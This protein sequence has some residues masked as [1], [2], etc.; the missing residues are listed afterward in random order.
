MGELAA[1]LDESEHPRGRTAPTGT[2]HVADISAAP[3]GKL[4]TSSARSSNPIQLLVFGSLLLIALIV[5]ATGLILFNLRDRVIADSER[6]LQNVALVLV[7][8]ADRQIQAIELVQTAMIEQI[9]A[10]GIAS[11]EDFERQLSGRDVHLMLKEKIVGL[12]HVGALTLV[13]SQGKIINYS[14]DWPV[15]TINAAD[16]EFFKAFQSDK[17]LTSFMGEPV[18]NRSSGTWVVQ[19]ARK[20][21]GP[22]G[23]FLGLVVGV[24]ELQYFEHLFGTITLGAESSIALF[25]R[26]GVL[27]ARYPHLESGIGKI[28]AQNAIFQNVLSRADQ[29]VTRLVSV[30]DGKERLAAAHSLARAP[31]V[32]AVFNPVDAVLADWRRAAF[33][34]IGIAALSVFI[35]AGVVFLFIKQL[36]THEL[37]IKA[38]AEKVKSEKLAEQKTILDA[39]LNNMSQGLCMFNSSARLVACN[40]RYIRMYNLSSAAVEPGCPLVDMLQHRRAAGTFV[41]EPQEYAAHLQGEMKQGKTISLITETGDGRTIS[42]VNEPMEN[43]GWVA[44]HEDITEA[45]RQEASFR[46]LFKNN[47]V[48]MWVFDLGS[49]RFLAVN[50]AAIAHYGYSAEQFLAMTVL[51]IRP[52]E[53][54]ER[55]AKFVHQVGGTHNGEQIWRHQKSD[56]AIIDVAIYSR[57]LSYDGHKAALVASIDLTDRKRAE[58]ELRRT[59]I[60]LNGIVEH[61]PLPIIVKDVA[62]LETDAR[63]SRFTLFNRAYEE[64]TGES[65]SQLIGKTAHQIFPK[66]RADLIV[67]SDN[68]TLQSSQA[69]TT[70]EHPIT[71]ANNGTRL[72]TAK[73]TIIRD[74]IGKPQYLLTVVDDVTER[75]LAEQRIAHMAH[76]D[77]LTDLPNRIAFSEYLSS[78][79]DRATKSGDHFAILSIDF[80][81]FKEIND[82]FGH[83]V[84][85][86]FLREIAHRLQAAT[87]GAFLARL[88]GDEFSLIV[89]DGPQPAAA[90]ALADRLLAAIAGDFEIE[91]LRLRIGLSIGVAVYPTDGTDAKLLMNNADAALYRAKDEM[92]GSV[93]FFDR[94][95]DTQLHERRALQN[96]LRLAIDRGEL[97]LHYQPQL[98]MAGG[99]IGLEALVR[100][101]CPKR[102]MVAPGAF[103]PIAEESSLIISIGEWVLREAC[104]EAA[105]WL[106]PLTIAV[107]VSP[108]QFHH[109]DLASFVHSI[110]LET[111]LAPTRLEL[112]ITEGVL[113]N[114]FSRAVSILRRLKSLGVRIALDDFGTGYSSLSYLQSFPFDKI[115]ID[116]AFICDLEDSHHSMAIVRAVIS[117]GRSLG[118]PVLAEGVENRNPACVPCAGRLRRGAGLSDRLA[119][120]DREL[121]RI[122]RSSSDHRAVLRDG[123]LNR[124]SELR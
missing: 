92:R 110:L 101:Q 56:K 88:G 84:G 6:E 27:L 32:V 70:I 79:L 67:R 65:R 8:Q 113:I 64:L 114:D 58:D 40:Q 73:K 24:V 28:F 48:P 69:V 93:Q 103:I 1:Q 89:A 53:E 123:R 71:T 44:T 82:V 17:Q 45:K 52:P 12:Q 62:G 75:R 61:V 120:A 11:S 29:G 76:H 4:T 105:S 97:T 50:E 23:E 107:N 122:G 106:R 80:D 31:I 16:R 9:Q 118:L 60:F 86:A 30:I 74:E 83:A 119:A 21:S 38:N 57:A 54:R 121:C 35:I 10:L 59:K 15:P 2:A 68:E 22:K 104:R 43:G 117:L 13:N 5:V 96:D 72:V 18:R 33:L 87:G 77:P 26:D 49:L 25:R 55:V 94:E 42:V 102:G 7:E 47:P 3:V 39:A 124:C 51:D 111:G 66:E 63:G 46:L 19:I 98:R 36:K 85:D 81:R 112:E 78:T 116:R 34:L 41:Q 100:W 99:T 108:I 109:G 91:G 115:K 14:R 37:L 95:M 90:S 20:V